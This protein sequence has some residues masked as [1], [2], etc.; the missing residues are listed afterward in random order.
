MKGYK[1]IEEFDQLTIQQLFDMAAKH[2][3]TNGMPSVEAGRCVYGGI[4][5]AASVFLR[6]EEREEASGSWGEIVESEEAPDHHTSFIEGL[7]VAHDVAALDAVTRQLRAEGAHLG[8]QSR[9]FV[10]LYITEMEA[11]AA[12]HRLDNSILKTG[13][14]K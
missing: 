14:K 2:V 9:A 1:T 8:K 6:P 13:V 4:G 11:V 10:K 7:Q 3:L 12:F 5:C